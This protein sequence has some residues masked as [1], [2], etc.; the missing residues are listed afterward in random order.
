MDMEWA[1][2]GETGDLFLLQ[3]RPETVHSVQTRTTLQRYVLEERSIPLATGRSVG[4]RIGAGPARVI[5]SVGDLHQLEPGEVLVTRMTDPDWEPVMKRAAAIVTDRGGRTCHAAIVSRELGIP[6]V[7]GTET[8]TERIPDGGPV[9]VS[10]AEGEEGRIYPGLLQFRVDEVE[11]EA[12]PRTR[13]RLLL[14]V[15]NPDEALGLSHLPAA[16]V[17]LARIEF[18]ISAHIQAHPMAL[19]HPER[20]ESPAEREEIRRLT[21]LYD[22][23][24]EFFVERLAEGVG[25]I[26]AAFW[27]REV[28]VRLSD[29]K[30]NEYAGLVGG[31]GSSR[32]RRTRCWGSAEPRATT[33]PATGRASRWSAPP[34]GGCAGRW[35][36]GT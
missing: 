21:E 34:C 2:D 28:V 16:G 30:T 23:G 5:E 22:S 31:R 12:I 14:N 13:T 11:L 4:E 7:V 6:A 9:T 32:W 25:T 1:R 19:L 3:A 20:V 27:P 29:F 36:S 8:G 35:G 33:T 17:G 18:I 26:A 15:G 10:C 24:A